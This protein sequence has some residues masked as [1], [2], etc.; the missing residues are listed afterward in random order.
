MPKETLLGE[1]TNLIYSGENVTKG[2]GVGIVIKTG[3]YTEG[4]L[5]FRN[6]IVRI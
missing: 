2:I 1:R 5:F 4:I 6:I 3:K